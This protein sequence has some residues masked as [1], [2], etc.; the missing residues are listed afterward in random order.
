MTVLT[1][2]GSFVGDRRTSGGLDR[3]RDTWS[4]KGASCRVSPVHQEQDS[5][6][7]S[8]NHGLWVSIYCFTKVE[9]HC[10]ICRVTP[11][12]LWHRTPVSWGSS[13]STWVRTLNPQLNH[14][15]PTCLKCPPRAIY[16]VHR[17]KDL[18]LLSKLKICGIRPTFRPVVRR[19][20]TY[21]LR[22]GPWR[23]SWERNKNKK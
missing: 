14:T 16:T 17:T 6:V 5:S 23:R 8:F 9:V 11:H 4:T 3:P 20:N 15:R 21:A 22:T 13:N 12:H 10:H 19:S 18:R 7:S 1:R 2:G